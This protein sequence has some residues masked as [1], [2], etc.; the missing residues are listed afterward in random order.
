[1]EDGQFEKISIRVGRRRSLRVLGI[2]HPVGLR[3]TIE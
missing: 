2:E 1:M 3:G